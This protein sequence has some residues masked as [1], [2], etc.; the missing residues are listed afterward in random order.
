MRDVGQEFP[1]GKVLLDKFLVGVC[2]FP[3]AQAKVFDGE[4]VV[5]TQTVADLRHHCHCHTRAALEN[6]VKSILTEF[7]HDRV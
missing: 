4:L 1:A 6:P 2:K 7:K 3:R 5:L